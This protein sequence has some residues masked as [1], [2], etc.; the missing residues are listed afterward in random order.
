MTR[1]FFRRYGPWAVVTGASSGI[2]EAFARSLAA[3]GLS[4]VLVAR[5]RDRLEALGQTLTRDHGVE[6]LIIE[7][8]LSDPTIPSRIADETRDLHV[9]LVVANAG[10]G[11][12]GAFAEAPA[13]ELAR[14]IDVNCRA[15][16]L[17]VHAFAPRL[18]AR[19]SGGLVITSST[20]A[21]QAVPFTAVYAAT[22]AFD[23]SLAEALAAELRPRGVDVVALCPGATDTEGPRRTGVDL[24]QTPFVMQPGPVAEAALAALGRHDLAVPGL[25]NRLSALVARL[26]PRRFVTASAGKVMAR[27][28]ASGTHAARPKSDG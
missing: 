6:A 15:T 4:V 12:K 24:S 25:T 3:R 22:K 14:M 16:T 2:G 20:A 13:D 23:L 27:T 10:F 8:D 11:H 19:G 7:A 17:L 1:G 21:F 9:G 5:R 18:V 26:L 28:I